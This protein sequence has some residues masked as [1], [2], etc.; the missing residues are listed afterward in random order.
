VHELQQQKEDQGKH[1]PTAGWGRECDDRTRRRLN[2][3]LLRPRYSMSFSP[4][5]L[6]VNLVSEIPG[7]RDLWESLEQVRLTLGEESV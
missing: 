5:S 7:L 1:G 6:L 4:Q 3:I 2:D